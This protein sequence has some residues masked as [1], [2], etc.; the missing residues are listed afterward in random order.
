MTPAQVEA[1]KQAYASPAAKKWI[2]SLPP[3]VREAASR[4]GLLKPYLP[5]P[6][7]AVPYVEE[8]GISSRKATFDESDT[9]FEAV[10]NGG[11]IEAIREYFF[12]PNNEE[13]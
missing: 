2:E 11:N 1:Y 9:A 7:F 5:P 12:N 8:I 6:S 4:E 3:A 10:Q 13:N